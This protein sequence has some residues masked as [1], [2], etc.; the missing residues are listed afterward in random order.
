[1][2]FIDNLNENTIVASSEIKFSPK[3]NRQRGKSFSIFLNRYKNIATKAKTGPEKIP[4]VTATLSS[5]GI[6]HVIFLIL[7]YNC[8]KVTENM[9][10]PTFTAAAKSKEL[11]SYYYYN[12][13]PL[14]QNQIF[15]RQFYTTA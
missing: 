1:M 13:I 3:D 5:D 6:N 11:R 8:G 14:Q 9:K 7:I 2:S 15:N 12:R 4:Y 10:I